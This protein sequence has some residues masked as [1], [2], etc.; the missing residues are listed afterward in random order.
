MSK[1][2]YLNIDDDVTRIVR[3][4]SKE[5][6]S[7]LTLVLPKQAQ[8]FFDIANLKTLK[9][10]TDEMGKNVSILTMDPKGQQKALEVGFELRS[11]DYLTKGS[12]NMDV[13]RHAK[14]HRVPAM[15]IP[16]KEVIQE[17]IVEPVREILSELPKVSYPKFSLGQTNS[18]V[19]VKDAKKIQQRRIVMSATALGL[20]VLLL[21]AYVIL[22]NAQVTIYAQATPLSKTL[23]LNVDQNA[24]TPNS[25]NLALPGTVIDESQQMTVQFKATGRLNKGLKAKGKVQIYNFTG[26]TLRLNVATTILIAGTLTYQFESDVVG[27]KPTRYI[28]GT[29]DPDPASLIPEVNIVAT[30]AGDSYNLP[31]GTRFEIKNEKLAATN[32]LYARNNQNIGGGT[33]RFSSLVT[34]QDIDNANTVLQTSIVA[35]IKQ[36]LLNGRGLV[37]LDSAMTQTDT[38]ISF[39]KKVDEEAINFNGTISTK[40]KAL[41]YD[42]DDLAEIVRDRIEATL[43][44]NKFLLND[45]R[46]KT[47]VQFTQA[48]LQIGK[49]TLRAMFQG[50]VATK[51]DTEGLRENLKGKRVA[52]AEKFLSGISGVDSSKV[53]LSPFWVTKI[54]RFLDN[55]KIEVKPANP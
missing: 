8:L 46:T 34:Q 51:F 53:L 29:R 41:A 28:E 54:P 15:A 10:R 17:R 2:L 38:N 30:Q 4:I 36:Q 6:V 39:D 35:S 31:G 9:Q 55:V 1:N 26:Q 42:L 19:I 25:K 13:G 49:G 14:P 20:V 12:R 44:S 18:Q 24:Q 48:D 11:L 23:E 33:T 32:Q 7:D 21:L 5:K 50:F 3:K 45:S 40:I 43:D 27:I 16:A 47:E 22:P 37:I 52:E